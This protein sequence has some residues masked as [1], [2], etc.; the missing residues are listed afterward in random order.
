MSPTEDEFA[1]H[2]MTEHGIRDPERLRE[3]AAAEIAKQL[4]IAK[5]RARARRK[6]MER[7]EQI[8]FEIKTAVDQMELEERVLGKARERA[9]E[10]KERKERK[11]KKK[12][13]G[14]GE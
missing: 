10:R 14:K 8:R 9:R 5:E 11:R 4:D 2:F 12:E 13:E 6:A 7:N 3:V 1:R